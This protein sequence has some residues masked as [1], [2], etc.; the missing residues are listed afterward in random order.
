MDFGCICG[1]AENKE[2]R[3]I[4]SLSHLAECCAVNLQTEGRTAAEYYLFRPV[5]MLIARE[6]TL[7]GV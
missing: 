4:L 1:V 2:K 7:V 6:I 5:A 3:C